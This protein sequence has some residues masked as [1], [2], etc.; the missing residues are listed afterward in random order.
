MKPELIVILLIL[1]GF[2]LLEML[3]TSFFKK[4]GQTRSDA[5]VEIAS[6]LS[7]S[8]ISQPVALAGGFAVAAWSC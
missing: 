4:P 8:I 3:F 6:T 2:A 1:I 7:V 5:I